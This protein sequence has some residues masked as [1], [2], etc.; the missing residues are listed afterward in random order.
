MSRPIVARMDEQV[1][2][3]NALGKGAWRET[4]LPPGCHRHARRR[5]D[6]AAELARSVQ[7]PLASGP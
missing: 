6:G 2:A 5:R 3:G 7:S 4:P 1:G